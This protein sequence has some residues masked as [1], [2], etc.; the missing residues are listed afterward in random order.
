MLSKNPL[1]RL[2]K[3]S[4]IKAHL[5]L[6]NFP[7][8]NLISLDMQAPHIPKLKNKDEDSTIIP[9]ISYIKVYKFLCLRYVFPHKALKEI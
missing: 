7:W 6:Q 9:F 3:I 4:H 1:S 8:D 5:W 2:C